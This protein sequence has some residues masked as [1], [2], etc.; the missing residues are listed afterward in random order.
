MDIG[1]NRI[2]MN[3]GSY[4]V[5]FRENAGTFADLSDIRI[6]ENA[7]IKNEVAIGN[8][9]GQ[10]LDATC[11]WWDSA[12]GP[13]PDQIE[14]DATTDPWLV[15]GDLN[16]PDCSGTNADCGDT[17]PTNLQASTTGTTA[18]LSWDPVPGAVSY[19]VWN[20]NALGTFVT[21]TGTTLT[22]TGLQ[23]ETEYDWGVRANCS[24]GDKTAWTFS[25]FV[26]EQIP[27]TTTP[28]TG[29][30]ETN[31]STTSADLNWNAVTGATAYQ[32]WNS[33]TGGV[34]VVQG[35]SYSLTG[36]MPGTEYDWGVRA[37][38]EGGF[39]S[40]WAFSTFSTLEEDCSLNP[41]T[42]LVAMPGTN[43][44]DLSWDPVPGATNYQVW[45]NAFPGTVTTVNTPTATLT[46]LD[47]ST[48]Y[49]WGV[50]V[51]C[52]GGDLGEWSFGSFTTLGESCLEN[53]PTNLTE[54]N[55][56]ANSA[57]LNWDPVAGATEYHVWNSNALG[58]FT[59]VSGTTFNLTGL[60]PGTE[61]DWGVR[62]VC[63]TGVTDWTFD[64]FTTSSNV[65][66]TQVKVFPNPATG[67]YVNVQLDD[68]QVMERISL[69]SLTGELIQWVDGLA[70]QQYELNFNTTL[71]AG[72][73]ML[74]IEGADFAVAKR[75]VVQ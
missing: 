57:D 20:S 54:T 48:S 26:T 35:T 50:R 70:D 69:Y 74:R 73:Y 25:S 37:V 10:M 42:G 61:Y 15:S 36:L 19:D 6:N 3:V 22:I 52:P 4:A 49:N 62:A 29:L 34:V 24:S 7:F 11:N 16:D 63:A 12:D 58:T 9:S 55:I 17:P 21:V 38:C 72:T 75:I 71:P 39:T 46:G 60:Q 43:S 14:G 53:P 23:P 33:F 32:V 13:T 51:V 1:V 64:S 59:T 65:L 44:V 5:Q 18:D 40:G 67:N 31:I 47:P 45:C 27:C 8:N 2:D 28:P 30:N 68:A 41:P 56:T 66:P